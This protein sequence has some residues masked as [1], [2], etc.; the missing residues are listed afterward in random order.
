MQKKGIFLPQETNETC[1]ISCILMALMAFGKKRRSELSVMGEESAEAIFY[2]MYGGEKAGEGVKEIKGTLGGAIA[3]ALG[4]RRL[5]VEL[6][7][8]SEALMEN[9]DGYYPPQMHEKMLAAHKAWIE[10]SEGKTIVRAGMKIDAQTMI[11]ALNQERLLIVQCLIE[12]DADGM[13]DHVLHWILVFD[14][15]DGAFLAYDPLYERPSKNAPNYITI[16]EE[17]MMAYMD[18][19]VGATVIC[20]GERR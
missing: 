3:Y 9:R 11:D 15:R 14:Y 5:S 16:G 12:G 4:A 7:H 19:P 2:R 1:G 6:W 13:H 17:E 10:K 8:E 20:V 18:T